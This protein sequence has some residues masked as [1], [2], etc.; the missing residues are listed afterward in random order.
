MLLAAA[1]PQP[2]LLVAPPRVPGCLPTSPIPSPSHDSGLGE[3]EGAVPLP[4][5]VLQQ[6]HHKHSLAGGGKA[7][8]RSAGRRAGKGRE[9][10]TQHQPTHP[11]HCH[12]LP[13][14]P[15]T[16]FQ[17]SSQHKIQHSSHTAL[18]SEPTCGVHLLQ[19]PLLD[20]GASPQAPLLLPLSPHR[21]R[22]G[23]PGGGGGPLGLL[24]L[25]GPAALPF[26]LAAVVLAVCGRRMVR[27][28]DA[29]TRGSRTSTV[30]ICLLDHKNLCTTPVPCWQAGRAH[31]TPTPPPRCPR[32]LRTRCPRHRWRRRPAA[33]PPGAARG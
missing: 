8:G 29:S 13:H 6:R 33:P 31:L 30:K 16:A 10:Q 24:P 4:Y 3:D 18:S 7:C 26:L 27:G 2:L 22:R 12:I 9:G 19:Q 14:S 15:N 21:G 23:G 17:P 28:G 32:S 5:Q 20:V 11:V 1:R 25:L